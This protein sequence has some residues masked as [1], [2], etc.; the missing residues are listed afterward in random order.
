[1]KYKMKFS[2]EYADDELKKMLNEKHEAI[3]CLSCQKENQ[4]LTDLCK[5]SQSLYR[6]AFIDAKSTPTMK[7]LREQE[8]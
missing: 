2:E 5:K 3:H 6:K 4:A 1:M 8:S 7:S